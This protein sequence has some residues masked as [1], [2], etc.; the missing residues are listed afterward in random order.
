M[1]QTASGVT[2]SFPEKI[3]AILDK[4]GELLLNDGGAQFAIASHS[5]KDEIYIQKYKI[6]SIF[7][8]TP[9]IYVEFLNRYGVTQTDN[10]ITAW[11]TFTRETPGEVRRI[12]VNGMNF[13][14]VY[15]ELVKSGMYVAKIVED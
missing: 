8:E 12:E 3:K 11:N 13:Y 1:F 4:Y 2:I 15:D 10:L 6:V 7:S 14:D 5:I 9:E